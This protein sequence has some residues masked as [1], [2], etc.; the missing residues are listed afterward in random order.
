MKNNYS[1]NLS[2]IFSNCCTLMFIH[3]IAEEDI[4]TTTVVTTEVTTTES[5]TTTIETTVV[6][7]N[8]SPTTTIETTV[9]T[10]IPT[11]T[12]KSPTSQIA[13]T[14]LTS[15]VTTMELPTTT[16]AGMLYHVFVNCIDNRTSVLVSMLRL[17][18]LV[19]KY[20]VIPLC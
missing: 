8:E 4:E 18:C 6:T 7:T 19:H 9:P 2:D 1:Q 15:E 16:V 17:V 11:T 12:T 14:E 13:T 5:P 3:I 10:T 20:D